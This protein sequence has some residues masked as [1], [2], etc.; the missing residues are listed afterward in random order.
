MVETGIILFGG[1]LLQNAT[2]DAARQVRT[3]KVSDQTV[4][5]N[6]ICDQAK[7]LLVNCDSALQI[8]VETYPSFA[9]VSIPNPI[10]A[11]GK[12]DTTLNHWQPGTACSIVLVRTF[13]PYDVITPLLTPFLVN[14]NSTQHLFTAAVA[15]R[16]EPYTTDVTGC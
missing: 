13:Y 2:N 6:L 3:G 8:D 9:S 12:L 15:F 11:T 4:F 7:S 5:K 16:N 14:I 1:L 10:T